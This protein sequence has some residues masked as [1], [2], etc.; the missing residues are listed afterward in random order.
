VPLTVV[1]F[2]SSKPKRW[3]TADAPHFDPAGWHSS[4]SPFAGQVQNCL[5]WAYGIADQG[6][7][8]PGWLGSVARH[9]QAPPVPLDS[10]R[11]PAG[12]VRLLEVDGCVRLPPSAFRS[13]GRPL[14]I[15]PGWL[16]AAYWNP[17]DFHIRRLDADGVWS[18]KQGAH[19]PERLT[20]LSRTALLVAT[21]KGGVRYA[22]VGLLWRPI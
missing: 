20:R 11:S 5:A 17:K 13:P 18:E 9:P 22:L 7:I 21:S 8:P 14:G 10:Y 16:L 6:F 2:M 1:S 12:L 15:E 19:A 4:T 3:L